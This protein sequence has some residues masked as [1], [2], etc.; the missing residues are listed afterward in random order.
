MYDCG[1]LSALLL[2]LHAEPQTVRFEYKKTDRT[3]P[4]TAAAISPEQPDGQNGWYKQP[5]TVS[6]TPEDEE[7]G[8]AQTEYSLDG[9]TSWQTYTQPLVFDKDG[10]YSVSYRSTDR[11]GNVEEAKAV[12]FQ[13]DAAPPVIT[14]ASPVDGTYTSA[15]Q[16]TLQFAVSDALSGADVSKT[17]ALLDGK[18]VQASAVIDLYQLEPGMHEFMVTAADLAGNTASRTVRFQVAA[19]LD[20][21]KALVQKFYNDGWIDN[22]GIANSLQSKLEQGNAKSFINQVE[23]QAGK[24]IAS[25]AAT[26]LLRIARAL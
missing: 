5:V 12:S 15:E 8:I 10:R 19:S 17:V 25:E 2:R 6:L 24:H 23:A 14:I 3:A 16:V 26:I 22:K 1:R 20:S 4:V 7:S 13:I 21:L 11:E 9:G 18:A